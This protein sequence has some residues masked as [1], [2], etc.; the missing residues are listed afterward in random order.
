MN[1][2]FLLGLLLSVF[3]CGACTSTSNQKQFITVKN[4]QFIKNDRPYYYIGTNFWYGAILGSEGEGGDKNRLIAE[5]DSLAA[6]GVDNLRIL[7]GAD[8]VN[9]VTAKVEPTLQVAPGVY[10]DTILAGLDYLLCEMDKRDMSAVL[11]LNNSW[12]WSGG[13]GQYLEW[14]GYGKAPIPAVD[15]WDK[16]QMF[17]GQYQKSDSCKALFADHVRN[18]VTRTNRY[19]GQGFESPYLHQ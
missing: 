16:F 7:V 9:G 4:G 12:E 17:V 3:V 15:G 1:T 2:H 11:Y 6:I 5:L 18:I 14:A 13:Y 10:N 19:T 8:G